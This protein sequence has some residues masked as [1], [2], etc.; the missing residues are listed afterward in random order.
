M[1]VVVTLTILLPNGVNGL[2]FEKPS[3]QSRRE[4]IKIDWKGICE[5]SDSKW[6]TEETV[7]H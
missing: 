1:F 5:H 7:I 3:S 2:S 6:H 4:N